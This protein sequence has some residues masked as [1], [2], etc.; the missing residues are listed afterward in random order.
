MILNPKFSC[1]LGFSL[2]KKC[3]L[4]IVHCSI[5]EPAFVKPAIPLP[6]VAVKKTTPRPPT[7]ATTK[8]ETI[9]PQSYSVFDYFA[10]ARVLLVDNKELISPIH[11]LPDAFWSDPNFC[12]PDFLLD[13][14]DKWW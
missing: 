14:I 3:F 9:V 1:F 8:E 7:P 10:N 4:H 12:F 13:E 6:T 2:T 5:A 11:R